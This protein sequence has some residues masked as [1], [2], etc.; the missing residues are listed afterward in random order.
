M[1]H[2][3]NKQSTEKFLKKF[4]RRTAKMEKKFL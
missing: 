1:K 4:E 2:T 3:K